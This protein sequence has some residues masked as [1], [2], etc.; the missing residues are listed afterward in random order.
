MTT[1]SS[2]N[3]SVT[4]WKP[5]FFIDRLGEPILARSPVFRYWQ[6]YKRKRPRASLPLPCHHHH[7]HHSAEWVE[8]SQKKPCHM[9][10]TLTCRQQPQRSHQTPAELRRPLTA[11]INDEVF[12]CFVFYGVLLVLKMYIIAII[13]GQVRLRKKVSHFEWEREREREQERRNLVWQ[14]H[15]FHWCNFDFFFLSL[16][17]SLP[18]K[19]GFR[20]PRGRAE[21]RRLAVSQRGPVRGEMPEVKRANFNLYF[22]CCCF[23]CRLKQDFNCVVAEVVL[24]RNYRSS[25]SALDYR[26]K[27]F[28]VTC[29]VKVSHTGIN[30]CSHVL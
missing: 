21:T 12:S 29:T 1:S 16:S 5:F 30:S 3:T 10:F 6:D 18:P 25:K 23:F 7:H 9:R 2:I 28:I 20:Q 15:L 4:F 27:M 24:H 26:F 14:L 22:F 8:A 17:P 19:T 13:T 11:M